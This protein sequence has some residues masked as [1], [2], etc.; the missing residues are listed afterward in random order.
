VRRL[1]PAPDATSTLAPMSL[2]QATVASSAP[3]MPWPVATRAPAVAV[4]ASAPPAPLEP[5][6]PVQRAVVVNEIPALADPSPPSP[7][8]APPPPP[9]I[10]AAAPDPAPAAAVAAPP[11]ASDAARE[12]ERLHEQV[13]R[14]VRAELLV[15]R[16]RAGRITD[17]R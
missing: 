6:R 12:R 11:S 4:A 1:A 7:S 3:S 8:V 13:L 2:T 14:W 9:P 15:N 5:A 16:E 10:A 17:L